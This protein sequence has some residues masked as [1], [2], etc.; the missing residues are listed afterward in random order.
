VAA[1]TIS[2][3]Y[4]V[5]GTALDHQ[6]PQGTILDVDAKAIFLVESLNAKEP[7]LQERPTRPRAWNAGLLHHLV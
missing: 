3:V 1:G 5:A 6:Y 2:P 4:P 7:R